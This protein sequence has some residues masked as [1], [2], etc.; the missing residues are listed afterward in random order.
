[1]QLGKK[2]SKLEPFQKQILTNATHKAHSVCSPLLLC[3]EITVFANN[4]SGLMLPLRGQAARASCRPAPPAAPGQS[5]QAFT[6]PL[7]L[8]KHWAFNSPNPKGILAF[9]WI[10]NQ[11]QT[12]VQVI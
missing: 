2:K 5:G 6:V 8:I 10:F 11:P 4:F 12:K 3:V 7:S 1:M 9:G